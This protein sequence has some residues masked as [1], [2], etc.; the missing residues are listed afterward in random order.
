MYFLL[1]RKK[2]QELLIYS[3]NILALCQALLIKNGQPNGM[4]KAVFNNGDKYGGNWIDGKL[5]GQGTYLSFDGR[6][7]VGEFIKGKYHGMGTLNFF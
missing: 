4:G 1:S 7:Y 2:N 3:D 6:K 5:S